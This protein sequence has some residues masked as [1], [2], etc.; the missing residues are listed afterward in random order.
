MKL[1]YKLILALVFATACVGLVI[2]L[3]Q[4]TGD[5]GQKDIQ[6]TAYPKGKPI[7][8]LSDPDEL[9]LYSLDGVDEDESKYREAVANGRE[10]LDRY[11]VLGKLP[12]TDSAAKREIVAMLQDAIVNH[13]G[14]IGICFLPRH[15]IVA[16]E[17]G[18]QFEIIICFECRFY[19]AEIDGQRLAGD[20]PHF[21][22]PRP[23]QAFNE[24][25]KKAGIPIAP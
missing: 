8:G 1:R 4:K 5:R 13:E 25:L 17:R 3:A 22:S 20:S 21:V 18:R 19:S 7:A 2:V 23:E 6:Q 10:T 15:A 9:I 16:K 11:A 24:Y 14:Y 12:I